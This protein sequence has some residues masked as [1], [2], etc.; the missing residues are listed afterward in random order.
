MS[1]STSAVSTSS[2]SREDSAARIA[3]VAGAVKF[4]DIPGGLDAHSI[5]GG[6]E[7]AVG[8]GVRG[9]FQLPEVFAQPGDGGRRVEDDLGAVQAQRA[10]T[11]REMAVVADV[12]ADLD[13]AQVED[14]KAEVAGAE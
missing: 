4:P 6:D 1:R 8:H 9:L 5:D 2:L 10:R 12:D 14:R 3:E 13:E 11:L 7:V